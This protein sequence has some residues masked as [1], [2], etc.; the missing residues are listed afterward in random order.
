MK[1]RYPLPEWVSH[2]P[3]DDNAVLVDPDKAYPAILDELGVIK[4]TKFDIETAYQFIKLDLQHAMGRFNFTI[5]I[6]SDGERKMR[7]NLSMF[8]GTK[9]DI[10]LA[11]KRQGAR[12]RYIKLRGFI[13]SLT[14]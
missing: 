7:W 5:H 9:E 13:P 3:T 12:R 11:T 10:L 6:R 4:P 2:H 8:P 1:T 14:E